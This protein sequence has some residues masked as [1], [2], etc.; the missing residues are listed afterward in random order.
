MVEVKACGVCVTDLYMYMWEFPVKTP[1]ILGHEFSGVI[2]E[3]GDDVAEFEVGDRVAVDLVLS[4]GV[5][6]ACVS[7]RSNLCER[8]TV[9]GGAGNVIVNGAFAEYTLVPEEAIGKIPTEMSFDQGAFVEPLGC[10]IHGVDVSRAGIGDVVVLIGAGPIGL[11]LLQLIKLVGASQIFAVD[12]KDERLELAATLGADI[13]INPS[14]QDPVGRLR[15]LTQGKG[16]DVVIEA[17]GS[18]IAVR[19]AVQMVRQGVES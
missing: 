8:R 19:Q 10:C 2:A 6:E 9:I 15:D 14:K 5:C 18:P 17:V 3:L 1:V 4:C 11:L 13:V 12:M 7:G 16:A